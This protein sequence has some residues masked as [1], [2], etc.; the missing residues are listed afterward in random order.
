LGRVHLRGK[1]RE[2]KAQSQEYNSQALHVLTT[3]PLTT[4]LYIGDGWKFVELVTGRSGRA[5]D[6]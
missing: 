6:L 1:T 4:T 3:Y 5:D 2:E